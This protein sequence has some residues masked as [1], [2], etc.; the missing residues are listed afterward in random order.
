MIW[1][2]TVGSLPTKDK[3][4]M[5]VDATDTYCPLYKLE[6]ETSLHLFDLCPVAK[7]VWFNSKWG[8][9][10]DSFGFSSEVDFILFC[11]PPL[12]QTNLV[13]KMSFYYLGPFSV[14]EFGS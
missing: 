13:K 14:M 11:V 5:F 2:I 4:S 3:L 9:R 8:L 7:A 1:R 12:F 10:M 6:T